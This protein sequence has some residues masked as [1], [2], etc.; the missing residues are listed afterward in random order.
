MTIGGMEEASNL[1]SS[2]PRTCPC[3]VSRGLTLTGVY[4]AQPLHLDPAGLRV[5][6]PSAAAAP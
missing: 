4:G 3:A 6:E 5:N 2:V 1:L